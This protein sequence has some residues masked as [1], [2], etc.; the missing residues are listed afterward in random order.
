M[1]ESLRPAKNIVVLKDPPSQKTQSGMEY[2][3]YSGGGKQ[4][5]V[6]VVVAIGKGKKPME[7]EV[8]DT[9]YYERYLDNRVPFG[10]DLYNFVRFDKLLAV[11]PKG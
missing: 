10:A 1:K 3:N 11:K 2:Q 8:G 5:E 4:P 6:G 9:V 7:F